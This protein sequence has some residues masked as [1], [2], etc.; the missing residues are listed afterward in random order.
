MTLTEK[1]NLLDWNWWGMKLGD[2]IMWWNQGMNSGDETL[3][4][5]TAGAGTSGVPYYICVPTFGACCFTGHKF[6][7]VCHCK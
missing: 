4:V 7:H 6:Y 5:E 3:E 1:K 2:E